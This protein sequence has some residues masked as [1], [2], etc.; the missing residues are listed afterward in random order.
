MS[1]KDR[2]RLLALAERLERLESTPPSPTEAPIWRIAREALIEE[3]ARLTR[4]A[5]VEV[6][7]N[8]GRA[9]GPA[10]TG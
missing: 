8:A 6:W 5:W 9:A 7:S 3:I 10:M 1:A 4:G 2:D